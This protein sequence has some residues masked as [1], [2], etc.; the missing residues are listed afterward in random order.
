MSKVDRD[1]KWVRPEWD[2]ERPTNRKQSIVDRMDLLEMLE[3]IR[4]V[5]EEV[6]DR[7]PQKRNKASE[8]EAL[9]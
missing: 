4:N 8:V 2:Y 9:K 7:L 6:R 3:S 5:L 1:G